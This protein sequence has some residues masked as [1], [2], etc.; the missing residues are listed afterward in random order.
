MLNRHLSLNSSRTPL[1]LLLTVMLTALVAPN[2]VRAQEA[3]SPIASKTAIN[4]GRNTF[5]PG[6]LVALPDPDG[7]LQEA[8]NRGNKRVAALENLQLA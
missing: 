7:T 4:G 3:S 2:F 5:T 8:D 6:D 1:L